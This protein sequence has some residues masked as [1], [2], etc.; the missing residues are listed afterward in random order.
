MNRGLHFSVMLPHD[1]RLAVCLLF[2]IKNSLSMEQI[3]LHTTRG[4]N[5]VNL[6]FTNNSAY[7]H[8]VNMTAT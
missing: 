4:K 3:V 1:K 2:D 5:V 8:C 6:C 7:I